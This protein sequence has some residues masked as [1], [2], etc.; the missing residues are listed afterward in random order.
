MK[1]DFSI[2]MIQLEEALTKK[3]PYAALVVSTTGLDRGNMVRQCATRVQLVQFEYDD[4][5]KQYDR[6]VTFNKLVAA[7]LPMVNAAIATAENGG[8]DVF[9]SAGID[10][11]SY[12][13]QIENPDLFKKGGIP[14]DQ[15]VLTQAEFK[16]AFDYTMQ[17]MERDNTTIIANGTD[18]AIKYLDK[19][20]CADKLRAMQEQGKV[21]DQ[22]HLGAEYLHK[23]GRDDLLS[24]GTAKLE[25]VRNFLTPPSNAVK[26]FDKPELAGDFKSMSKEDFLKVHKVSERAYDLKVKDVAFRETKATAMERVDIINQ[27]ITAVGRE[28]EMLEPE[29]MTRVRESEKHRYDAASERG[30][31]KYR[32]ASVEA[33]LNTLKE[34]G[35]LDTDA[36]DKGDSEYHKLMEAVHGDKGNKGI[37]FVHIATSGLDN[38][39]GNATGLP[40]Q[41]VLHVFDINKDG[42]GLDGSTHKGKKITMKLPPEV[43]LKAEE[44]IKNGGFD[45]FKDAGVDINEMK[46]GSK[47]LVSE[48]VFVQTID[49]LFK[50]FDPK[51]YPI[52]ALSADSEGK[53]FFQKSLE[54]ICTF[55]VINAPVIDFTK[56]TA[57][58]TYL[59]SKDGEKNALFGDNNVKNLGIRDVAQCLDIDIS[60][61]TSGKVSAMIQAVAELYQ[62][63][64]E[65]HPDLINKGKEE[66][67]EESVKETK[68]KTEKPAPEPA[69]KES[70]ESLDDFVEV[71]EPDAEPEFADEDEGYEDT[72][73][74]EEDDPE[75]EA[76]EAALANDE[77]PS[78]P[79]PEEKKPEPKPEQSSPAPEKKQE[80][81]KEQP[82]R[83]HPERPKRAVAPA[84]EAPA[85]SGDMNSIIAALI[86][87]NTRQSELIAQQSQIIAQQSEVIAKNDERLFTLLQQ[88]NDLIKSAFLQQDRSPAPT[89]VRRQSRVIPMKSLEGTPNEKLEQIK[90]NI[91]SICEDVPDKVKNC[92]KDA[93][94]SISEGQAELDK[95][96]KVS[97]ERNIS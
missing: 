65:L 30:K 86:Q 13:A 36:V 39:K 94:A 80:E 3:E 48:N 24:Y 38:P 83:R 66:V 4:E 55:D 79:A 57:E 11:V 41:L 8:Y 97:E 59:M 1:S 51:E 61:G 60:T 26:Q 42:S 71:D 56:A 5:L 23:H 49:N 22:P 14:A 10:P 40:M 69:V 67:K 29:R 53:A 96:E 54:S 17:G 50:Q 16:Q 34:M 46:N 95:P 6:S 76:F 72:F 73:I 91:N 37:A 32:N 92:L 9:A 2:D 84:P 87:Q 88:Q 18:F 25:A 27:F 85:P 89:P 77:E 12:K 82:E 15:K 31:Q 81:K 74:E 44:E 75:R 52:V 21:I 63:N 19:L 43:V 35:K 78:A 64:L 47:N 7:D 68:A 58:Y 45:V 20:G 90:D 28:K 62:Q 33:K 70:A 93:N